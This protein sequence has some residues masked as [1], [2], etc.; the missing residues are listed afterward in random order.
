MEAPK[1]GTNMNLRMTGLHS[2]KEVYT[3]GPV[4]STLT[5]PGNA[6]LSVAVQPEPMVE[7][8]DDIS[9]AVNP[10][11]PCRRKGCGVAFESNE[12]HRI[13]DGQGTICVYHPAPVSTNGFLE[14]ST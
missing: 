6:A 9:I 12:V 13:G 14:R 11:A 2:G 3:S 1:S 4:A 10:G 5:T 8:E 7:E